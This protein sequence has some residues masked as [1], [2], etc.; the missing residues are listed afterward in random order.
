MRVAGPSASASWLPLRLTQQVV[1]QA[2]SHASQ[3]TAKPVA[4]PDRLEASPA[5]RPPRRSVL[6]I[7]V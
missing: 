6:D 7:R 4:P 3:P 2:A 1:V 5:S